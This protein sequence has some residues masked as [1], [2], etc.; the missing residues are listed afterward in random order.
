MFDRFRGKGHPRLTAG[1]TPV[2]V[3]LVA[4]DKSWRR[5]VELTYKG[6]DG[7]GIHRWEAPIVGRFYLDAYLAGRAG[8]SIDVMPPQTGLVVIFNRFS[9]E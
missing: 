7:E 3:A 5:P 6:L 8:L 9:V 1:D 2:N 4:R